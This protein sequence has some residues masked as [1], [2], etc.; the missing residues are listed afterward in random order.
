MTDRDLA[1]RALTQTGVLGGWVDPAHRHPL[2]PEDAA[3]VVEALT[4]AGVPPTALPAGGWW[5]PMPA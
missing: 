4:A 3:Q 5:P 1:I 2:D